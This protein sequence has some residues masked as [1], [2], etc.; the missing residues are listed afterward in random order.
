MRLGAAATTL[1]APGGDRDFQSPEIWA[2]K[3]H[4]LPTDVWSLGCLA[5]LLIAGDT[6][7]HAA[8]ANNA[9]LTQLGLQLAK[10]EIAAG[11][12]HAS[13]PKNASKNAD[14]FVRALLVPV[15][16]N[17]PAATAVLAHAWLAAS[18]DAPLATFK[19]QLKHWNETR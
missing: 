10:G 7:L 16:A 9:N 18:D 3:A 8:L 2:D 15:A 13:W 5:H 17:R 6:P 1:G 19:A 14:A 11:A 4:G 12:Q